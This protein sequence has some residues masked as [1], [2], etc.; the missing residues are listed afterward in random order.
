MK[1]IITYCICIILITTT[2]QLSA[3][4][5]G[6][7]QCDGCD[8]HW[9]NTVDCVPVGTKLGICNC[10]GNEYNVG[11]V[12]ATTQYYVSYCNEPGLDTCTNQN[13][14]CIIQLTHWCNNQKMT[15]FRQWIQSYQYVSGNEC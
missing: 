15:C 7:W 9:Y 8:C 14:T 2:T 6:Y 13:I 3:G 11:T 5:G 1:N 4:G 12:T 10:N